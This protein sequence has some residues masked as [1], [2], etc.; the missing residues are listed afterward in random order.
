MARPAIAEL[1]AAAAATDEPV[2][3]TGA[4]RRVGGVDPLGLRQLNFDLMDQILP[5]LNNVARHVRPFVVM[6]WAWRRARQRAE[7]IGSTHIAVDELQDFVDRIEV[8][9]VMS[10]MLRDKDVDLPGSDYLA[11]WLTE[12]T[13]VFGGASWRERRKARAYSTALSAPINYGPALRML[14][15]VGPHLEF[16]GVMLPSPAVT[17][18]LDAL[19]ALL[20]PALSHDA[21]GKFGGVTVTRQELESWGELWPLEAVSRDEA[22]VMTEL[23]MGAS[24]TLGR[25]LG[26]KLM[27]AAS[28]HTKSTDTATL[29]AAMS[30]APDEFTPPEDLVEI[31]DLWRTVQVRQLFRLCLESLLFW[32][33]LKLDDGQPR[34]IDVLIA[35]FL[36]SL[37]A[38]GN[39]EAGEWIRSLKSADAGPTQL[40]DRIQQACETGNDADLPHSVARGLALCLTEPASI[41][42]RP[43][44]TERLPLARAQTEAAVRTHASAPEFIRHVLESWVLA[45]HAYWSVGRGLADARAGGRT[46]LR[47][48]IFLDEGGWVLAPGAAAKAPRPTP[49]RLATAIS[50]ANECGLFERRT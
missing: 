42:A 2:F 39:I 41:Q 21:F 27:L 1:T 19:E 10:Q 22:E 50:L 12:S 4:Q 24:A 30:G 49:D 17:P 3:V 29:R 16:P 32:M 28:G 45:Q 33:I 34:S 47:L 9:F 46:L 26:M 43:Q 48:R 40:M 36:D 20:Q 18:A 38:H 15:W 14:G 5:G 25:R 37:P 6:A 13:I 31:R 23:L 11:P 35:S 44:Q 8:L 7:A